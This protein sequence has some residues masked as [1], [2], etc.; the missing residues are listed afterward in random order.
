MTDFSHRISK[1]NVNTGQYFE[2][3][4]SS[5]IHKLDPQEYAS[6]ATLCLD[7]TSCGWHSYEATDGYLKLSQLL[8]EK[9]E[10]A[11]LFHSGEFGKSLCEFAFEP[12]KIYFEGAF[13]L[14]KL[15]K[16][17]ALKIVERTGNNLSDKYKHATSLISQ[18]YKVAFDIALYSEQSE[19]EA[20]SIA[21]ELILVFRAELTLFLKLSL[22]S[23][24]IPW[25]FV[26]RV[27]A[28]KVPAAIK[29]LEYYAALEKIYSQDFL[30]S[31][32]EIVFSFIGS[33]HSMDS[34]YRALIDQRVSN[35]IFVVPL[36][37]SLVDVR[38]ATRLIMS[39]MQLPLEEVTLMD[40]WIKEGIRISSKSIDAGLAFFS[41]ESLRS[42]ELLEDLLGQI[43]LGDYKRV[44]ELYT[45]GF[46]SE[47]LAIDSIPIQEEGAKTGGLA[48]TDGQTIFLPSEISIFRSRKDNLNYLKVILIH[49]LGFFE[50]GTF[51]FLSKTNAI[52][53]AQ[54]QPIL[55]GYIFGLLEHARI[56]WQLARKF[57]GLAAPIKSAKTY[58]L[59]QRGL[60]DANKHKQ[61]IE[62][63]IC[64]SLDSEIPVGIQ[65]EY[66]DIAMELAGLTRGLKRPKATLSDV[67]TVL[68][69]CCEALE[70]A[71]IQEDQLLELPPP[72]VFRG[73]IISKELILNL[74]A[75]EV[76][77]KLDALG[78]DDLMSLS[79]IVDPEEA[80]V[81]ELNHSDLQGVIGLS[82]ADLEAEADSELGEKD[83]KGTRA[84][85]FKSGRSRALSYKQREQIY[86]YDE[87]DFIID[88]YRRSWCILHEIRE[89]ELNPEFV[90]ATLTY[91]RDVSRV[92]R[93]R[94]KMLKP[95]LLK[96]VK[97]LLDGEE[98]DLE[99]AIDSVID[100]KI[101][102]T[103]DERV[104][105]Q[106]QRK[107]RD[108]A[109]LFLIDM[110]ASTDDLI[111]NNDENE[112]RRSTD[113]L[114]SSGKR[115]IDLEKESVILMAEAL[116]ELGD[117]YSVSGFSGYGREQVE[118]YLCKDFSEPF[119]LDVKGRIGGIK[120]NRSTRMGPAI[121][122][123][124]K[125][126]N[127]VGSSIQVLI[128]I[129]D[130]YPQDFD[131]GEDRNSREYGIMDT[132]RSISE[133]RQQGIKTFCLTVDPA[134][135]D[136]MRSICKDTE[137]MVIH[138]MNEL[139]NELSKIYRS[140]T[141]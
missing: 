104:Y 138:N 59:N 107:D 39:S 130:G 123:A 47:K 128:I 133:A 105:I 96:K 119:N 97:G 141:S 27:A 117:S 82:I 136:Y 56:D 60:K 26:A 79:T 108:V 89:M 23:R 29:Y 55:A 22:S 9:R 109:A 120:P 99:R 92:V 112:M 21:A 13:C 12:A 33:P 129:S 30:N 121:R 44:F 68:I 58:A 124:A 69:K 115:I 93:D 106:R 66:H 78:R 25:S 139:P 40:V 49:Q 71:G 67:H 90:E 16:S 103:Q 74:S 114:T 84:A 85:F 91:H 88:D 98:V 113:R 52:I 110:S 75:L 45:E 80:N 72:V 131:Y 54:K 86:R 95:Q 62:T 8:L 77:G 24:T 11:K 87:W 43:N 4:R 1:I 100:K 64:I 116:E 38:L 46:C 35:L 126:L 20:W 50:F 118:Y 10:K 41:L 125:S 81:K 134:G 31:L 73:K 137:Y 83:V 3:V 28:A 70:T 34:F 14:V 6:W 111:S 2:V 15:D 37:T 76:E 7:I 94:F 127:R 36:L 63:I 101:S 61:L 32:E 42:L 51:D 140:L 57:R 65:D 122:H 102:G 5:L 53:Q 135:H 17:G 132:A 18:Y 48:S 19:L